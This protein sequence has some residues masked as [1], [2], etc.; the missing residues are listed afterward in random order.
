MKG[1][2]SA[3]IHDTFADLQDFGWQ[4]GYGAFTVSKSGLPELTKYIENQREHHRTR[5]FQEEYLALLIRHEIEY[6][7]RYLWD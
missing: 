2:S 5:T 6:D 1:G 3:W 7:E 4:D